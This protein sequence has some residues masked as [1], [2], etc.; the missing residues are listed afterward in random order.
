[1]KNQR[2]ETIIFDFDGTIADT[3]GAV[4]KIINDN[5]E[6]FGIDGIDKYEVADLRNMSIK[7]LLREF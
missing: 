3:F 1:M 2:I 4:V 7:Y 5:K 6:R